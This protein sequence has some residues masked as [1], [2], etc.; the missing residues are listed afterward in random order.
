MEVNYQNVCD[1]VLKQREHKEKIIRKTV[2]TLL[3]RLA[4]LNCDS[5][6]AKEYLNISVTYLIGNIRKDIEKQR[7]FIALG[8]LAV[9]SN[10]PFT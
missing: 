9:V 5:F 7:C 1:T 2:I 4:A 6:V 3:P 8:E 10:F